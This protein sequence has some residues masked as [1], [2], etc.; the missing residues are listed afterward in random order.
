LHPPPHIGSFLTTRSNVTLS[1][2]GCTHVSGQYHMLCA[3]GVSTN[4]QLTNQIII[5][6]FGDYGRMHSESGVQ[7]EGGHKGG[8]R[9]GDM[10]ILISDNLIKCILYEISIRKPGK[11]FLNFNQISKQF[12]TYE[13]MF[14]CSCLQILTCIMVKITANVESSCQSRPKL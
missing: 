13:S 12:K 14:Y 3:S 11:C 10:S 2:K 9:K 5:I 8:G 1:P 7:G 6:I 4:W